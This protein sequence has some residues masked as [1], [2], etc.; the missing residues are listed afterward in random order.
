[1]VKM[2]TLLN[3]RGSIHEFIFVT[4]YQ[5]HDSN[6]LDVIVPQSSVK[7]LL[8]E[9]YDTEKELILVFLSNNFEVSNLK[10]AR[11]YKN[12]WWIEVFLKWIKQNMKH[13]SKSDYSIYAIMQ[14]LSVSAFDKIPVW[15]LL[16]FSQVIQN[17]KSYSINMF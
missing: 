12:S 16:S 10:I 13:A 17:A 9:Y 3:S 6:T 11:L 5:C 7:L 1:M 4:D 14:I 2:R 8:V 15:D